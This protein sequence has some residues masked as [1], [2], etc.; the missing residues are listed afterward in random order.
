MASCQTHSAARAPRSPHATLC[1]PPG[2]L[3]RRLQDSW[4]QRALSQPIIFSS[5]GSS[6]ERLL[7]Q[8]ANRCCMAGDVV[9]NSLGH[10]VN[11]FRCSKLQVWYSFSFACLLLHDPWERTRALTRRT[12]FSCGHAENL[13]TPA[14]FDCLICRYKTLHT[15]ATDPKKC[16][17][18][19][20]QNQKPEI[21]KY[22]LLAIFI[23]V[24]PLLFLPSL[25][26]D[27]QHPPRQSTAPAAPSRR[28]PRR[29]V[30]YWLLV[31]TRR[32]RTPA[33]RTPAW[34]AR[35]ARTTT[36]WRIRR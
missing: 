28:R 18:A 25:S 23:I 22:A 32:Q 7:D 3:R 13:E 2:R 1:R 10:S 11:T 17:L 6:P 30:P 16:N 14:S 24:Y 12:H 20:C 5:L 15:Y 4:C 33:W 21:P 27:L 36:E 26:I 9:R 8:I 19:N 34:P 31:S 35:R 29:P